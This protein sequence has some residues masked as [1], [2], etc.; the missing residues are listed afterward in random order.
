M[1]LV[2][3]RYV[4]AIADSGLNITAAASRLHTSQ[5]GVSRQLILLEQELGTPL[6][7]RKGR[8]LCRI[9]AT[10]EQVIAHARVIVEEVDGLRGM[11]ETHAE[12]RPMNRVERSPHES[13]SAPPGWQA[14]SLPS[15][16][17]R[18]LRGKV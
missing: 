18:W 11:A 17:L 7:E 8:S 16:G 6:F 3:L 12:T 9:T 2:Q 5:P 10:G 13:R 15:Q 14:T 4:L 1:K